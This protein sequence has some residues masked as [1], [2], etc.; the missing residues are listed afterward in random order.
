MNERRGL[1][2]ATIAIETQVRQCYFLF[3]VRAVFPVAGFTRL[4]RGFAP[5]VAGAALRAPP[6]DELAAVARDGGG[7]LAGVRFRLTSPLAAL[8]WPLR[9]S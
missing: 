6:R 7:V 8:A 9:S 5:R 3:C 4:A 2:S 1:V